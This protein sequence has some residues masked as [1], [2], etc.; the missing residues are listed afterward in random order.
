MKD[1]TIDYKAIRLKVGF[2]IHQQLDT[3]KLFCD[4]PSILR[5]DKPDII[6]KRKLYATAGELGNIDAAALHE[7]KKGKTFVYEA[8]NNTTCLVELDEEPPHNINEE[9]LDIALQMALLLNAKIFRTIQ[10]MRK[11]VI[12]GSNT[13]GFQRTML[14]AR[15]GHIDVDGLRVGIAT[16]CLEEEAARIIEKR[17]QSVVYRLD[18]LGIPLIEI[19][20]EP[21]AITPEQAKRVALKIGEVLRA[22]RIKRGL[23]TIRQDVNVSIAKGV[24]TE[25]KGVQKPELIEKVIINEVKRQ[26]EAVNNNQKLIPSVRKALPD[27]T[28]EFMRPMPGRARMYPETDLPLIRISDERIKKLKQ[29]LPLLPEQKIA[30][31]IKHGFNQQQ[32]VIIV[33]KQLFEKA[34]SLIKHYNEPSI[35]FDMVCSNINQH[36][37]QALLRALKQGRITKHAIK[38]MLAE[39][40]EQSIEEGLQKYKKITKDELKEAIKQELIKTI[41]NIKQQGKQIK[42]DALVGMM[43]GKFKLKADTQEIVKT[44]QKLLEE[45]IQKGIRKDYKQ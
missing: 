32:A 1:N 3:H 23:G 20:T 28:T 43:I 29:R 25:I 41:Q 42:Q 19:T 12:D 36:Q 8:Y 39:L 37:A 31:L 33:S 24:R 9:A 45:L 38:Q 11:T 16:V 7:M 2:E 15:N 4:C 17:E 40:P 26:L 35:I 18:R 34:T 10:V 6:V 22:C 5:N 27:G 44:C 21:L 30:I 14:I 13:S